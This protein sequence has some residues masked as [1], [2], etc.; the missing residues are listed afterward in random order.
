MKTQKTKKYYETVYTKRFDITLLLVSY[1][2]G[3]S[4]LVAYKDG[5]RF[6]DFDGY[7]FNSELTAIK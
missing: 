2:F 5:K 1:G 3:E 4:Y 6:K 7:Y